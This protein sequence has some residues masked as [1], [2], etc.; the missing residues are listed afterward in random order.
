MGGARNYH[1]KRRYGITAAD[2]DVILAAQEGLCAICRVALAGHVDHDHV[3]GKVRGLLCCNCIG[4]LGQF[5]DRIDVLEA[6]VKYLQVHGLTE[7]PS[8]A[9]SPAHAPYRRPRVIEPFPYRGGEIDVERWQHPIG[10]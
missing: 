5:K 8:A 2:A 1:L 4:G 7:A 3:T 6:A 10:A 9:A